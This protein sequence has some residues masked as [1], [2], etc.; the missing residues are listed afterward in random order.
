MAL[1]ITWIRIFGSPIT[2]GYIAP[3][4]M[5][6]PPV[7]TKWSYMYLQSPKYPGHH[8]PHLYRCWRQRILISGQ[9]LFL[10]KSQQASLTIPSCKKLAPTKMDWTLSISNCTRPLYAKFTRASTALE[11]KETCTSSICYTVNWGCERAKWTIV[12]LDGRSGSMQIWQQFSTKKTSKQRVLMSWS[13]KKYSYLGE[14]IFTHFIY[15][16]QRYKMWALS[17]FRLFSLF[18]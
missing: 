15:Q 14:F 5:Y 8:G 18:I 1:P 2:Q 9:Y 13:M 3:S 10:R 4:F 16:V 12:I 6:L 11:K 7:G 17:L